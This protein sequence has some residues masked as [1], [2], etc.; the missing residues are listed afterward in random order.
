MSLTGLSPVHLAAPVNGK[1]TDSGIV[2]PQ[3]TARASRLINDTD[4]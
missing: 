4:K 3:L 1:C 2:F